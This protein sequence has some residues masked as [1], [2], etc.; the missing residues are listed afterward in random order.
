MFIDV[1]RGL[2]AAIFAGFLAL[3][4]SVGLSSEKAAD[5]AVTTFEVQASGLNEVPAVNGPGSAF[6]RFTFDDVTREL[7]YAVTVS[8]FS[9]DQVTASHIHRGAAGVNGPI[10]YPLSTTGFTQVAGK[11]TLTDADVADLKAGNLYVNVHSLANPGGFARGQM[12]LTPEAPLR[13]TVQ[14]VVDAWNKGDVAGFQK[15]WTDKGIQQ[16]F[17]T[18]TAAEARELVSE[19]IGDPPIGFIGLTNITSSGN[20]ATGLLDLAFGAVLQRSQT[21]YVLEGG[22]WKIDSFVDVP[23]PIPA[24][25]PTV[26]FKM[27]EFAFV[28]DKAALASGKFALRA[29][30]VG[31]QHHEAVIIKIPTGPALLPF[32]QELFES[33]GPPPAGVDFVAVAGPYEPGT[34]TNIVFTEPLSTG[35]YVFVC[36]VPDEATGAPHASL[37]MIS[38]FTVTG[39]AAPGGSIRAPS[40][41]DGGLLETSTRLNPLGALA[42]AGMILT[43]GAGVL[44]ATRRGA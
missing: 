36:G 28:Y 40:T 17:E 22:I 12:Y 5:A 38:E 26:D 33:E 3:L 29:E 30:N 32:I 43:A 11:I 42:L 15:Y 39:G 25:T 24:G 35:R 10:I 9:P 37:G 13:A 6:A 8:G 23:A 20:T 14:G 27:Q 31:K 7:T 41:G 21:T 4:V 2:L 44:V 34:R 19:L 1:R 18:E 16:L